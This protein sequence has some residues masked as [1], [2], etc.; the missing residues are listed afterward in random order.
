MEAMAIEIDDKIDDLPF[1][2][3]SCVP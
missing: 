2:K 3:S 1:L